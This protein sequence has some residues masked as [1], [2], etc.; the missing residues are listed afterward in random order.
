[1][2]G[3]NTK[4]MQLGARQKEKKDDSAAQVAAQNLL[5]ESITCSELP[6]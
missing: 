3:R 6:S 2:T 1:M 4:L 5:A